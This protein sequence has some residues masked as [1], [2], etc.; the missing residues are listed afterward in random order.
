MFLANLYTLLSLGRRFTA[1][2]NLAAGQLKRIYS[3]LS[4]NV[5]G[6]YIVVGIAIRLWPQ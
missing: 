6:H 1:K 3:S 2:A 4:Q 5:W